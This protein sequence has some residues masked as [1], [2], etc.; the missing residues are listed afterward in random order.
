MRVEFS[1]QFPDP[2]MNALPAAALKALA[3]PTKK[4]KQQGLVQNPGHLA[5]FLLL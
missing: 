5:G 2:L 4:P 3:K 1:R